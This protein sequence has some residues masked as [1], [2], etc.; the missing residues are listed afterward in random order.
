[1]SRQDHLD[2]LHNAAYKLEALG[3][4]MDPD[5]E[6]NLSKRAAYG[7]WLIIGEIQ[8]AVKNSAKALQDILSSY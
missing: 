3:D 7:L 8:E 2:A 1:M 4:M 6:L 5:A